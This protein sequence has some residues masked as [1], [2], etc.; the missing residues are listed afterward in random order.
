[1]DI[2]LYI[3]RELPSIKPI[4]NGKIDML[5]KN[6]MIINNMNIIPMMVIIFCAVTE[7]FKM[8]ITSFKYI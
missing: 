3:D 1:M 2:T 6:P 5:N 8:N 4:V 7:I